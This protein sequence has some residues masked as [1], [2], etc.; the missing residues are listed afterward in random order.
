MYNE[1]N[2][3]MYGSGSE[4]LCEILKQLP[5][6]PYF[7]SSMRNSNETLWIDIFNFLGESSQNILLISLAPA[8]GALILG[9]IFGALA[10][11]AL[12]HC[13]RRQHHEYEQLNDDNQG[14]Q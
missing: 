11:L 9:L 1:T 13:Y 12:Q 2:A 10:S 6:E 5:S 8:V 14:Q 3:G 4:G 7:L